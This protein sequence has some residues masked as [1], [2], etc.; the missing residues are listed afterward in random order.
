MKKQV[1]LLFILFGFFS[2]CSDADESVSCADLVCTK[3]F[4]TI[5]LR[6]LDANGNSQSVKDFKIF[7]KRIAQNITPANDL[8]NQ[9]LYVIACDSDLFKFSEKGDPVEVTATDLKTNAPIK[10]DYVISGGAC[11]CHVAKI[12]GPDTYKL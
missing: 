2:S 7:N 9:G 4:R 12:S 10:I 5:T 3:E 6:F 11:A 8:L 1:L